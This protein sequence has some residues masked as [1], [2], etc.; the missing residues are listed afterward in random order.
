MKGAG[1]KKCKV[2][3]PVPI[4]IKCCDDAIVVHVVTNYFHFRVN[5]FLIEDQE[6]EYGT[7]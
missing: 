2:E 3:H 5:C 4:L 6:K 1:H 7:T